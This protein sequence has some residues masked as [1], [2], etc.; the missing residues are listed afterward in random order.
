M[1][2]LT[3]PSAP[4]AQPLRVV[5]LDDTR[6]TI[7]GTA[8]VSRASAEAVEQ[9]IASGEFD[10]V[11][12]EL[13][14]NRYA[15]LTRPDS[16]AQLDLFKA[17]RDGKAAVMAANLA[18]GAFQQRLAEQLGVEPGLEMRVA[19]RAAAERNLPLLLIDRDIGT[20][21]R[22][23][24]RSVPWWQRLTL[25]GGVIASLF[26]SEKVSEAEIER[27]KQ[28]D[29]LEATF[30][31]FAEKSEML[32]VP[33]VAER[34]RYMACRLREEL[35]RRPLKHVLVVV[36]AGHLKGLAEA[37]EAPALRPPAEERREL[38]AI[39]KGRNWGKAI[40]WLIT[41]LI[42]SGFAIGF[43]RSPDLGLRMMLD[44]TLINGGLAAL[45]ATIALAHPL[46]IL[47]VFVAAPLTS[48]N[49]LVGAGFVAAAIELA[50]RRPRMGDF[51]TLRKDVTALRG[52]WRNRVARTLLVFILATLG[53]AMGTYL[54]GFSV[55]GRLIA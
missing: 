54:G 41:A 12:V 31:E 3:S 6:V 23:V 27:L 5:Q 18:L 28:G 7:L 53:S 9:L 14:P 26:V 30:S 49:P 51:A 35:A 25:L 8:H 39:P 11:A 48:L 43:S 55:F 33:L 21:L 50:L 52:W 24:Y 42:L 1:T 15:A 2:D 40:P 36:G 46:T 4:A 45:G 44:W 13:D 37:L 47:G 20:T 22:R 34:D 38:E 16:W 17:L 10:A 19:I 32:Y 29:I